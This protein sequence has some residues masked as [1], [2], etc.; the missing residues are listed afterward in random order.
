MLETITAIC[1]GLALSASCGFRVFVPMLVGG[2]A[3]KAGYLE[4]AQEFEWLG[5][6]PAIAIFS[7][8][9]VVEIGA[10]YLPWL[11][12]LLDSITVPVAVVAGILLAA[13]SFGDMDPMLKWSLATV[14][15][16]GT[17]GIISLGMSGLRL[18]SSLL[19]GGS[20]NPVIST[21]EWIGSLILSILAIALPI[22]AGIATTVCAIVMVRFAIR[23]FTRRKL[24]AQRKSLEAQTH[25]S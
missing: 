13:A 21:L 1:L 10:Y 8:A 18:G 23:F 14:A 2:I 20:G 25:E 12:N 19:T 17:A 9:T 22:V 24:L 4:L 16:G 5:T 3:A 6:W 15:G 7:V 11:D